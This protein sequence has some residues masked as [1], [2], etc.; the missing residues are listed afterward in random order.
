MTTDVVA[1]VAEAIR[2]AS[3]VTIL[4][5]AGVSAASG[6]PTFRGAG[7][8][9][10]N[11]KPETLA[12]PD[13]FESRSRSV[14]EWYDWR[15]RLIATRQP[16]RGAC[17]IAR[18][19]RERD[20]APGHHPERRWPARTRRHEESRPPARIDLDVRCWAG[21]LRGRGR[22]GS[23]TPSRSP[24]LPPSCPHCGGLARPGV[25]WFGESLDPDVLASADAA[26]DCDLFLTI[27][28]SA[29]VYPAAGLAATA[30]RRGAFV[31][32]INPEATDASRIRRSRHRRTSRNRAATTGVSRSE[33][34][35]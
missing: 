22:T 23:T 18:W 25:V 31:A 24:T 19:T 11:F 1:H 29:V 20:R 30:K 14:W 3:R 34:R 5:G 13:A 2:R 15:R 32:E 28:T 6:I 33:C 27:G 9:W 4:T 8:L 35:S 26:C 21:C 16:E 10:K 17:V 12:T 7:G